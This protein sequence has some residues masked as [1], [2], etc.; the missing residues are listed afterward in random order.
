MIVHR[1]ASGSASSNE[2]NITSNTLASN[3][4]TG[5]GESTM[6]L[7]EKAQ[8]ATSLLDH[9]YQALKMS[10]CLDFQLHNGDEDRDGLACASEEG[11]DNLN[12]NISDNCN[13]D[14]E[15][16]CSEGIL[17]TLHSHNNNQK[18]TINK[19]NKDN[20]KNMKNNGNSKKNILA[21]SEA[22]LTAD[23]ITVSESDNN[24]ATVQRCER[25]QTKKL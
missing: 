12:V 21:M 17:S 10:G 19:G 5:A 16:T 18:I 14:L 25:N 7:T 20:N 23:E 24:S 9:S 11:Q 2:L 15:C 4:D 22:M 13:C 8:S 3:L 6:P 1:Q